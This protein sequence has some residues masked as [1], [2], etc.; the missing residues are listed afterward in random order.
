MT[1]YGHEHGLR[2]AHVSIASMV[3]RVEI[4]V[5]GL[6]VWSSRRCNLPFRGDL[7]GIMNSFKAK[8]DKGSQ[9]D[10]SSFG[11]VDVLIFGSK[12]VTGQYR[13]DSAHSSRWMQPVLD[14]NK[15][16]LKYFKPCQRRQALNH[17]LGGNVS[18][19]RNT[20]KAKANKA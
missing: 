14:I 2:Y 1:T 17:H 12:D 5:Q 20:Y 19:R 16:N 9:A 7:P 18:Q 15:F 6:Q 10:N 11:N 13:E 8:A 3:T 4:E